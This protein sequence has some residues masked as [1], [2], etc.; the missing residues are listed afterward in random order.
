MLHDILLL[1][2]VF[3]SSSPHFFIDYNYLVVTL[4]TI[5][6]PNLLHFIYLLKKEIKFN[7]AEMSWLSIVAVSLLKCHLTVALNEKSENPQSPERVTWC[8]GYELVHLEDNAED[9][10]WWVTAGHADPVTIV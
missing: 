2:F 10:D 7:W 1:Y 3:L 9:I 4:F 5:Y 8:V 6:F